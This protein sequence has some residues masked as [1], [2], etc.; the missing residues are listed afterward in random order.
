MG[1]TQA[2]GREFHERNDRFATIGGSEGKV[3]P[4]IHAIHRREGYESLW[5]D[6]RFVRPSS[7]EAMTDLRETKG[8]STT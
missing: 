8:K 1:T 3:V 7:G 5:S 4:D 2:H 6:S